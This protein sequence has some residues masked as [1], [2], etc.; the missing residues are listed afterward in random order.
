M[1]AVIFLFLVMFLPEYPGRQA[2]EPEVG[3]TYVMFWNLENFFDWRRDTLLNSPSEEEFTSFGRRRWTKRRFDS[4]SNAIAK[5]ILWVEDQEGGLPDI[6]GF[7]EVENRY[8]LGRLLGETA[9]RRKDYSIVHF[10]SPDPR[11]IDVAL[12]YR[13]SRLRLLNARPLRV[14]NPDPEGPPLLTRD[15][16]SASFLKPDGDSIVF[17]VNHHPSKYGGSGTGWRREAALTRLKSAADSLEAAGYLNIVA[18][19]DFNDTPERTEISSRKM[20][21][22]AVK[23]AKTGKGTIRFNGKWELIDMFFVS[24]ALAGRVS[25]GGMK[26]LEIPF[27]TTQDNTHSGEKPLRTYLGPRYAGGVSDHR[28]ILLVIQ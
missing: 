14:F 1:V 15:I 3:K 24:N 23:P 7:A 10:E 26:I 8:V 25:D 6:I 9:L 27:L 19:G 20:V 5:T 21:N 4:K 2:P 11:G 18:M 16:L 13:S 22:L 17:L 12:L 28:P